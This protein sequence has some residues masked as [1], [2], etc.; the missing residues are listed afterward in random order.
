METYTHAS[1]IAYNTF[2]D[3]DYIFLGRRDVYTS[4][5]CN[6]RYTRPMDGDSLRRC[7]AGDTA[8]NTE[9]AKIYMLIYNVYA[10]VP[11]SNQL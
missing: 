6:V 1:R 4:R 11:L 2:Y 8:L 9:L 5:Y 3:Y 7:K 10:L